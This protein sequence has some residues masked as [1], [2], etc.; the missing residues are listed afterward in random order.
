MEALL[1]IPRIWR[2]ATGAVLAGL[3]LLGPAALAAESAP[4]GKRLAS[5]QADPEGSARSGRA[6]FL[7]HCAPCHGTDARG[8]G[9]E[10]DFLLQRP[11]DLTRPQLWD[12]YA[13]DE[14]AAKVLFGR[15]QRLRLDARELD[16]AVRETDELYR[17][18]RQLPS[19]DWPTVEAGTEVFF[20]R[21][22]DCH[23]AYGRP[24]RNLPPG[25][26]EP[27]TLSGKTWKD[28]DLA[29][30]VRHGR[31]GMPALD[32]PLPEKDVKS[33]AAFVRV[34][35][36]GFTRYDTYCVD[37]HGPYGEGSGEP[38]FDELG[39]P[40]FA[41][42]EE[43]FAKR[44]EAEVRGSI[45]HMIE[46]EG[47]SMPHFADTLAPEEVVRILEDLQRRARPEPGRL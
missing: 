32:P 36:P 20:R 7:R 11:A 23:D 45:W 37:C 29:E 16:R 13:I 40:D 1:V 41:F 25:V 31:E 27:P 28:E 34:L 47:S 3:F 22:I 38:P 35:S 8:G 12:L 5:A 44:S 9:P 19:F 15:R 6:L 18:L 10:S 24:S 26:P 21:C 2:A 43:Y 33:L 17:F 42:D 14:L 46:Q 4:P 39:G 30:L